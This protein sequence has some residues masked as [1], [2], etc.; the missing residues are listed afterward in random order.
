MTH[1]FPFMFFYRLAQLIK[2]MRRRWVA[3]QATIEMWVEAASDF[4]RDI[5]TWLN[6]LPP[7]FRMPS[8]MAGP[9]T[10]PQTSPYLVAQ[11]SEL[12]AMANSL[13]L[14]AYTPLLKRSIHK[15]NQ[16]S[17]REAQH[18][19][20]QAAH[21]IVN[22]CHDLF[23]AFG[24]TRPASYVFYSF[25]RQIF[26]AAAISAS[27]VIQTPRSLVAEP[28][29]KDLER[30]LGLMRHPVVANARGYGYWFA[31]ANAED[32][33]I[34]QP[35]PSSS[36]RIVEMLHAKATEAL[37]GGSAVMVGTKRKHGDL[38]CGSSGGSIPHG[39]TLPFV[40]SSLV[41]GPSTT[42]ANA[43]SAPLTNKP[44]PA[45]PPSPPNGPGPNKT[46]LR[47]STGTGVRRMGGGPPSAR[48]DAGESQA[49]APAAST[50]SRSGARISPG[51]M[52]APPDPI[53]TSTGSVKKKSSGLRGGRGHP[54]I[55]V[56]NRS[57]KSSVA[58]RSLNEGSVASSE[59]TSST[60]PSVANPA[61]VDG[62]EM[63]VM[64]A[65][66]SETS[67]RPPTSTSKRG[68]GPRGGNGN[69]GKSSSVIN[70]SA[71]QS[72]PFRGPSSLPGDVPAA[73]SGMMRSI[74]G[75]GAVQTDAQPGYSYGGSSTSGAPS[76]S[77]QQRP[78]PPSLLSAS[79]EFVSHDTNSSPH[80]SG[81]VLPT[82]SSPYGSHAQPPGQPSYESQNMSGMQGNNTPPT[83][84]NVSAHPYPHP[85]TQPQ[86]LPLPPQQQQHH[87]HDTHMHSYTPTSY[88]AMMHSGGM[89]ATSHDNALPFSTQPGTNSPLGGPSFTANDLDMKPFTHTFSTFEPPSSAGNG[90]SSGG[91]TGL[92]GETGPG[93][94]SSA[95][96]LGGGQRTPMPSYGGESNNATGQW[97]SF[98]GTHSYGQPMQQQQHPQIHAHHHSQQPHT[99]AAYNGQ[100][101][102]NETGFYD[103]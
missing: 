79:D 16:P 62:G 3:E 74:S 59:G 70:F 72:S 35:L 42:T 14:K 71:P 10:L 6:E 8:R 103:A 89:S 90:R 78:R 34:A 92:G 88:D 86:P 67:S 31:G 75:Y 99:Q 98:H 93:D 102:S 69:H 43:N 84:H 66:M 5:T 27:I 33:D 23:S 2:T 77:Q 21:I 53:P 55:G 65:P 39:F 38:D 20:A 95:N 63:G 56:R 73:A 51:S 12:A 91:T 48:S 32:T 26:A 17:H 94:P 61:S 29:M 40:G 60:V 57:N 49:S 44:T 81:F 100:H 64:S 54:S 80:A 68:V 82:S 36:L 83:P 4:E 87:H 97:P 24:Q 19:C 7:E 76:I 58:A 15:S 30:A 50:S 96:V 9:S 28:A 37:A 45:R 47:S 22:A 18:S 52:A 46:R 101:W 11:R 41:T 85:S 25:G 13:I 1:G